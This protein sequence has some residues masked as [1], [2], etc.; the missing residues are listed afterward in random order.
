MPLALLL[1]GVGHLQEQVA[2]RQ[3]LALVGLR[4]PPHGAGRH[5]LAVQL[6][7]HRYLHLHLHGLEHA[8]GVAGLEDVARLHLV[9]E[10]LAGHDRR[11]L[12]RVPGGGLA[13]A[14]LARRAHGGVGV[15]HGERARHVLNEVV[16]GDVA[17]RRLAETGE[18]DLRPAGAVGGV[19][20]H[21]ETAARL[22]GARLAVQHLR[23][24]QQR[25]EVGALGLRG[26]KVE[27]LLLVAQRGVLL[28]RGEAGRQVRG[29]HQLRLRGQR[30]VQLVLHVVEQ[31]VGLW[32]LRH[33]G[34]PSLQAYE[35]VSAH[36]QLAAAVH[37]LAHR[38]WGLRLD[39]VLDHE[40]D[41]KPQLVLGERR[42]GA[43]EGPHLVRDLLG[44]VDEAHVE[45]E[46][47]GDADVGALGA[48]RP[49]GVPRRHLRV[50]AVEPAEDRLEVLLVVVVLDEGSFL[51][52]RQRQRAGQNRVVVMRAV[53]AVRRVDDQ[54]VEALLLRH[55]E[56]LGSGVPA[57]AVEVVVVDVDDGGLHAARFEN[58]VHGLHVRPDGRGR[59]VLALPGVLEAQLVQGEACRLEHVNL[60]ASPVLEG[61]QRE[62]GGEHPVGHGQALGL[63]QLGR[64]L[65][66]RRVARLGVVEVARVEVVRRPRHQLAAHADT[67]AVVARD[68][69]GGVFEERL[70]DLRGKLHKSVHVL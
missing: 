16:D 5:L 31:L 30:R 17:V 60:T 37:P 23:R 32:R 24:Q 38:L 48:T 7:R 26:G 22:Q 40:A 70:A 52:W 20:Q 50:A 13:R 45:V 2:G 35:D 46:L 12:V 19:H 47:L 29:A 8:Q 36:P 42:D 28:R 41:A 39:A 14:R 15:G 43:L 64:G 68:Q 27:T 6:R 18:R 65:V 25:R 34:L 58:L 55:A 51:L 69:L 10:Q 61:L 9:R 67:W 21:L 3:Q 62:L 1:L 49:V 44:V 33:Q 53:L 57:H 54:R 66:L 63:Q 11:Q 56:Q 59:P 4:A